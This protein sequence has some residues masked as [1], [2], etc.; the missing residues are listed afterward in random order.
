MW[1]DT[2]ATI[3]LI[4]S[5]RR[6]EP[7][8]GSKNQVDTDTFRHTENSHGDAAR[9]ELRGQV[10]VTNPDEIASAV[11]QIPNYERAEAGDK[12]WRV[13]LF[14]R[15]GGRSVRIV[16]E[17][18]KRTGMRRVHSVWRFKEGRGR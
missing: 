17:T 10:A 15:A 11:A 7:V 5:N 8:F 3:G 14:V 18:G 1:L 6:R 16:A 9:V 13:E 2:S 4:A 12:P